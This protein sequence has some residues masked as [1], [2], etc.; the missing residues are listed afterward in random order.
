MSHSIEMQ[1]GWFANVNGDFSG[2]VLIR[3][4]DLKISADIPFDVLRCIVVEYVR[5]EKI[6]ALELATTAQILG[7]P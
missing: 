5:K 4:H 2:I 6:R 1:D 7:L 3:N